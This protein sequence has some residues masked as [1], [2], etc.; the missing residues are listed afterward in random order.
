MIGS[1]IAPSHPWRVDTDAAH[2]TTRIIPPTPSFATLT[3]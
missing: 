3:S 1:G 2:E